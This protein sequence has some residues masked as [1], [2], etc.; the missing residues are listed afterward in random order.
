MSVYQNVAAFLGR[1]GFPVGGPDV[2]AVINGLLYDMQL[3]LDKGTGDGPMDARQP[4]IP[5]WG[6]PPQGAPKTLR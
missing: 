3:G 2:N 5:T 1:N 4:M 6:M